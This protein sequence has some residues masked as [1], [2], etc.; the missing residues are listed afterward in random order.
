[1]RDKNCWTFLRVEFDLNFI[2][3]SRKD[4]KLDHNVYFAKYYSA[5]CCMLLHRNTQWT[6]VNMEEVE[7]AMK[8]VKTNG[9]AQR[10]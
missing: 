5:C 8:F 4:D 7:E 9:H 10:A 1:M 2:T 3:S 6:L